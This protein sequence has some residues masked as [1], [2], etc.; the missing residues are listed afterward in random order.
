MGRVTL[1]ALAAIAG[2]G[3]VASA[4]GSVTA[5][6]ARAG[7]HPIDP[8]IGRMRAEVGSVGSLRGRLILTVPLKLS[9]IS[10]DAK[11]DART[12]RNAVGVGV[13]VQATGRCPVTG[14]RG[15]RDNESFR[16][17][18]ARGGE[19]SPNL[20]VWTRGSRFSY[21]VQLRF[22]LAE[23]RAIRSAQRTLRRCGVT[24]GVVAQVVAAQ[25]L[26]V[27]G[28]RRLRLVAR[29]NQTMPIAG[30]PAPPERWVTSDQ[31]RCGGAAVVPGSHHGCTLID[32]IPGPARH[33]GAHCVQ[34][35]PVQPARKANL[36]RAARPRR[37]GAGH[38]AGAGAVSG[39]NAA[40][41]LLGHRGRRSLPSPDPLL[42]LEGGAFVHR[43]ASRMMSPG[44]PSRDN[45]QSARRAVSAALACWL[46]TT[47]C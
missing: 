16:R 11:I 42:S 14:G 36:G 21:A 43:R 19:A 24:R 1:A 31:T 7:L 35:G 6:K 37:V 8:S 30:S 9:G 44:K 27:S 46:A 12:A 18:I 33:P 22:T 40:H 26:V 34:R 39:R 17:E 23:T 4:S 5:P 25:A 2:S 13:I 10:P 15:E 47:N 45:D 28:I 32:P 20:P 29:Q 41:R 38:D 3:T